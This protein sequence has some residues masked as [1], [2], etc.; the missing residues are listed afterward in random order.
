MADSG[1]VR[2]LKWRRFKCLHPVRLPDAVFLIIFL[3]L[4][5]FLMKKIF[6]NADVLYSG[7]LVSSYLRQI[8]LFFASVPPTVRV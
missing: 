1:Q 2:R 6:L 5:K 3:I 4:F 7:L 8:I